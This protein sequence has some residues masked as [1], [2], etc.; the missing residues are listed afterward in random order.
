MTATITLEELKSLPGTLG[1][2]NFRLVSANPDRTN[3]KLVKLQK[4]SDELSTNSYESIYESEIQKLYEYGA[5]YPV[6]LMYMPMLFMGPAAMLAKELSRSGVNDV[7]D[8]QFGILYSKQDDCV[9][10][11]ILSNLKCDQPRIRLV[12]C[13]NVVGVGFDGGSVSRVIHS[14][15]PRNINDYVQEIGRA[16]RR[17]QK[18]EAVLYWNARDV[19]ANV[20]GISHDII[21]YCKSQDF[22]L[23]RKLL[24][25]YGYE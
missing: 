19:A 23:R 20:R 24:S 9:T 21:N 8:S 13:T 11:E 2:K 3:I 6:T 10:N 7:Y 14:K 1:M 15:P 17:N 12:F 25:F 4:L 18:A 16:G 5:E 22:C